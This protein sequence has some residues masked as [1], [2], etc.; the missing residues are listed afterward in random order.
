MPAYR[1]EAGRDRFGSWLVQAASAHGAFVAADESAARRLARTCLVR[2]RS[3]PQCIGVAYE[4]QE[5]LDAAGWA[6]SLVMEGDQAHNL[7][8]VTR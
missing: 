4:L 8:T 2:R 1:I 6:A 7:V 3:A 5:L